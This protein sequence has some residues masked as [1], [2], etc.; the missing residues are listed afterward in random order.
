MS[1]YI[2]MVRALKCALLVV[3]P[4]PYMAILGE[5][6]PYHHR[7]IYGH[8]RTLPI[9]KPMSCYGQIEHS[10][11]HAAELQGRIKSTIFMAEK[12]VR[13]E[14]RVSPWTRHKYKV[15]EQQQEIKWQN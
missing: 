8:V 5:V 10:F 2:Y 7:G 9:S 13:R 4:Y 3:E 6:S 1:G 15:I 12:H 14:D 11:C